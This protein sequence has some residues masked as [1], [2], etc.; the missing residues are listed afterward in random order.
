CRADH[1]RVTHPFATRVPRRAFPFD[2]HVLSTPPAFVL[3]QNQTLQTKTT[4]PKSQANSN[5]NN[6]NPNKT[7]Q[8]NWH[9]KNKQPC[10]LNEKKE[11]QQNNKQKPP[12]T[13]LSSQ[14]TH[15][16]DRATTPRPKPRSVVR[17]DEVTPPKWTSLWDAVALSG[18]T[19]SRRLGL[20]YKRE[21]S[22]SNRLLG[23]VFGQSWT[24]VPIIQRAPRRRYSASLCEALATCHGGSR[25]TA[26]PSRHS[27]P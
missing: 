10:P 27:R 15:P 19:A 16:P 12:N 24:L 6:L 23:D 5:Q 4:Q 17:A 3:S 22:E 11:T 9:Q 14:T 20:S 1:P 26:E 18:W 25:L 13:L 2:L 21:N 7:H 8:T